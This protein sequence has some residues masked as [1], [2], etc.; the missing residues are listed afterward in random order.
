M[1]PAKFYY[2]EY[3]QGIFLGKFISP[4]GSASRSALVGKDLV[5]SHLVV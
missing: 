5:T 3:V 2:P 1:H 4:A